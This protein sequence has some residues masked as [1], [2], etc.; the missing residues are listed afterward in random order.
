VQAYRPAFLL[1]LLLIGGCATTHAPA[2]KPS[3]TT[4]ASRR[5]ALL[6]MSE[7]QLQGRI[8]LNAGKEGWSG[9]F[10][11][12]Q[13]DDDLDVR[14]SGPLG[15]GGF[16]IY[17]DG[18]RLRVETSDGERFDL[19]D[20]ENDLRQRYGWSIPLYSMRY[21]MLGVPDPQSHYAETLDDAQELISLE[22]RGWRVGYE[23]FAETE[24]TVLPHK[25][26]MDGEGLRIKVLAERWT[27]GD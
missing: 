4:W 1:L 3:G 27:L 18:Q 20:P 6:Q 24:G 11:W 15:I 22:Q 2:P 16:H 10:T 21:W 17:G 25:V 12:K 9:N 14:F 26:T 13:V 23:G 19:V 8:A 7:W 5:D